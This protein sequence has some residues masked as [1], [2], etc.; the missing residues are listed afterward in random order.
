MVQMMRKFTSLKAGTHFLKSI[1]W[2]NYSKY[3]A[4]S[5]RVTSHSIKVISF[6]N[7]SQSSAF[8]IMKSLSLIF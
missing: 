2:A 7:S 3:K 8:K 4:Q 1:S 6:T 5:I